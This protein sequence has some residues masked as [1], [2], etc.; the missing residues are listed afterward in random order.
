[1]LWATGIYRTFF[2]WK[3]SW[4]VYALFLSSKR[5]YQAQAVGRGPAGLH[6]PC[7]SSRRARLHL[8]PSSPALGERFSSG[9]VFHLFLNFHNETTA[10]ELNVTTSQAVG[11]VPRLLQGAEGESQQMPGRIPVPIHPFSFSQSWHSSSHKPCWKS[12][13]SS[14]WM[15][16]YWP[17]GGPQCCC[18]ALAASSACIKNP[19]KPRMVSSLTHWCFFTLLC[20]KLPED[21]FFWSWILVGIK[22]K[23]ICLSATKPQETWG[24]GCCQGT[25][26]GIA[27]EGMARNRKPLYLCRLCRG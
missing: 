3:T 20:L 8:Q 19:P 18:C 9:Y 21:F 23:K 13:L 7:Q 5:R 24:Q 4:R 27:E 25:Q 15:M 6:L 22:D 17:C 11:E 2:I 12:T 16:Q 26:F 10:S 1:M 14:P